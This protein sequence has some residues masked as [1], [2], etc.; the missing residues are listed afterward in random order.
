M[1]RGWPGHESM[2]RV[3]GHLKRRL[4]RMDVVLGTYF[5]SILSV[6]N[7]NQNL[8]LFRSSQSSVLNVVFSGSCKWGYNISYDTTE[9]WIQQFV[10]KLKHRQSRRGVMIFP[11]SGTPVDGLKLRVTRGKHRVEC[12]VSVLITV[13]HG[14]IG[15]R[16]AA[17]SR[18]T[19]RR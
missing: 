7:T 16:R 2:P 8:S 9:N 1:L 14:Q 6:T 15:S 10:L 19:R 3:H 18:D 17:R 5:D 13:G 12:V 11:G 4:E